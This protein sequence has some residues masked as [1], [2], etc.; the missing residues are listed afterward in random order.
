ML[1]AEPLIKSESRVLCCP[2]AI[3]RDFSSGC[4]LLCSSDKTEHK[5]GYYQDKCQLE[6]DGCVF[7]QLQ[8][9]VSKNHVNKQDD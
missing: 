7:V 4:P 3:Y 6:T 2:R 1:D 8:R 9:N 5:Q